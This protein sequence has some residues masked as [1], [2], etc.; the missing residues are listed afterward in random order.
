MGTRSTIVAVRP[1]AAPAAAIQLQVSRVPPWGPPGPGMPV[2]LAPLG[3]IFWLLADVAIREKTQSKFTLRDCL[4]GTM[5]CSAST[6]GRS[7]R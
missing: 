7:I 4:R 1:S 6:P 5:A 2:L 3:A